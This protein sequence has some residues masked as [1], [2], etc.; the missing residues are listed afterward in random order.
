MTI[1]QIFEESGPQITALLDPASY[2][3]EASFNYQPGENLLIVFGAVK[4]SDCDVKIFVQKSNEDFTALDI[5]VDAKY[6]IKFHTYI[7][8]STI[9]T[10]VLLEY[11]RA[12]LRRVF[13]DMKEFGVVE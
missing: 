10:E 13:E 4:N 5:A 7:L 3:T 6:D 8:T 2:H 1:D 11:V 12:G 9:T